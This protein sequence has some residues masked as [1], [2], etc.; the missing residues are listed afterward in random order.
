MQVRKSSSPAVALSLPAV[1]S[2]TLRQRFHICEARKFEGITG[3]SLEKSIAAIAA[4]LG[5]CRIHCH[6]RNVR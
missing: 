6:D 3:H 2:K 5:V 1:K 4:A